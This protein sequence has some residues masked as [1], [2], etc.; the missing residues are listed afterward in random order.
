MEHG[1]IDPLKKACTIAKACSLVY[2]KRFM[3]EKTLAVICPQ[4][5][6]FVKRQYSVKVLRWLHYL[7]EKED[8]WI[9]Q[10]SNGG[11]EKTIRRYSVDGW[12]LENPK[13][14][15]EFNGC[16]FHGCPICY[17][18][19]DTTNPFLQHTMEEFYEATC[20]RRLKF[21]EHG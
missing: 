17:L 14:V 11:G 13:I 9:P 8:K 19:R 6:N 7:C 20:Q 5:T 12:D 15:Y 21:E 18:Q 1:E 3:P 10:A 4:K 2:R 16:L